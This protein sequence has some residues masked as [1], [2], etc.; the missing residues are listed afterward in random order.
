MALSVNHQVKLVV[1]LAAEPSADTLGASIARAWRCHD[2]HVR[3]VGMAG[4]QMRQAGVEALWDMEQVSVMG[5]WEVLK[6]YPR[7]KRLQTTIKQQLVELQP[8]LVLGI[9]GPDFNLPIEAYLRQHQLAAYHLVA[10][11]VWAW[12][13]GR[14][15]KIAQQT[16]GLLCLFP[17]EPPYFHQHQLAA[18]AIGHPL[19]D[20][21]PL[22]S[23]K[24]AAR[25]ALG[26]A[27]DAQ[28]VA[29]LPGSRRSEWRYNG[30]NFMQAA[31]CLQQQN[32][33]VII[34][35]PCLHQTMQQALAAFAIDVEVHWLVDAQ[36]ARQALTA[37]DVALIASGT[38]TLEAAL[39]H[40]PMVMAYR[41]HWL[42]Q[43]IMRK[44]IRTQWIALPN[45]IRQD[46]VLPELWQEEA[47]AEHIFQ[48]IHALLNSEQQQMTQRR[49]YL[50]IHQQLRQDAAQSAVKQLVQW[51]SQ[52]VR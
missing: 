46:T 2:P 24:Q 50:E 49:I 45:I 20:Q 22:A 8:D 38:A 43:W 42:T 9:D 15:K 1:L 33:N 44:L 4:P 11:S 32:P 39:C 18:V 36:G 27:A 30:P 51:W 14:A 17:F 3:L 23:D 25:L 7:L 21:L 19:A 5:L 6:H 28:V 52:G 29:V 16:A 48:Q 41:M 12:R 10:P 37:A 31:A 26:I 47:T 35:L 13:A 40:T 34:L